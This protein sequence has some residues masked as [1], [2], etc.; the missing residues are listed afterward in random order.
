MATTGIVGSTW[1][2]SKRALEAHQR[3]VIHT[4]QNFSDP[5]DRHSPARVKTVLDRK[6]SLG[7]TSFA[8]NAIEAQANLQYQAARKL[9]P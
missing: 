7:V 1:A 9:N 8:L 5:G 4:I 3:E 2:N 6:F